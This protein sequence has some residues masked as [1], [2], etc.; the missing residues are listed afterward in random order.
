MSRSE[1]W[2]YIHMEGPCIYCEA[3]Q[4]KK[5][6]KDAIKYIKSTSEFGDELDSNDLLNVLTR[7]I[8]PSTFEPDI[9]ED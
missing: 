7:P 5:I 1:T 8:K 2:C 9:I 3:D 4:L 6:V